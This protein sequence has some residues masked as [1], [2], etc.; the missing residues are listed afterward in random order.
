MACGHIPSGLGNIR[1]GGMSV[2]ITASH[3]AMKSAYLPF[4]L[5]V[6]I[7]LIG[8]FFYEGSHVPITMG[9]LLVVFMM[10]L[11]LSAHRM[12]RTIIESLR[13]RFSNH[14]LIDPRRK[15]PKL[16]S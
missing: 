1:P 6:Y 13:L 16:L 3:T 15:K 10:Y 8:R 9:S 11:L 12:Q 7:P 5:A 4:I 2:G 14:G